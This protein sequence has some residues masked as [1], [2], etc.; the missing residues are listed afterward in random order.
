MAR[1]REFDRDQALL[2]ARDAFWERGYEGTSIADLVGTLG[3]APARIYAAF[4][5]KEGLFREAV[6]LYEAREGGFVARALKEETT[7]YG[8]IERMLREAV[9]TYTRPGRPRGCLVVS[10][11]ASCS[12]DNE[13]IRDWLAERRLMQTDA[14]IARLE[15]AV[16]EGEL[17]P[18]TDALAL[19]DALA[20][21]LNGLSVLARDGVP[22]AR[23]F[24]LCG[25]TTRALF[26]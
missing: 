15:R 10:A 4:G 20:A 26:V 8:A 18:E 7:A 16:R 22:R 12:A 6:A 5:S 11:V 2:K 19:G 14:I 3:L 1:P 24:A 17:E 21:L 9:E 13:R 23:L 25:L